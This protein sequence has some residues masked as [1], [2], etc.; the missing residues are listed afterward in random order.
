MQPNAPVIF[1]GNPAFVAEFTSE[2]LKDAQGEPLAFYAPSAISVYH[3]AR[4][5]AAGAQNI[6][7]S[8]GLTPELL[9][10]LAD[11]ALEAN[12]KRDSNAVAVYLNN[13][14]YRIAY[15]VDEDAALRMAMI[16]TFV[17]GEDPDKPEPHWTAWKL[18]Q[19]KKDPA[20]YSFFLHKGLQNTPAYSNY[21]AEISPSSLMQRREALAA[22]SIPPP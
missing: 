22:L 10:A 12:N 8:A 21:L 11:H 9:K 2:V 15:P 17:P 13:I 16:L 18:E 1:K 7:S 4:Y 6:F 14:K 20:A 19:V 3:T 5:V